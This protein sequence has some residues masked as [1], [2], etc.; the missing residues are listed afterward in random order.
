MNRSTLSP[1][2]RSLV[3]SALS[4]H[5]A[6]SICTL[7]TCTWQIVCDMNT[8]SI[9]SVVFIYSSGDISFQ[10]V[11]VFVLVQIGLFVDI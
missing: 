7:C 10:D 8:L 5:N 3:L 4:E 1:Y 2:I 9:M 6:C 11:Y